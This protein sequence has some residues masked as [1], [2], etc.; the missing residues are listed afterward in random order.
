VEIV[1]NK[2]PSVLRDTC[3]TI[4]GYATHKY[5]EETV[6]EPCQIAKREYRKANKVRLAQN[7][8]IRNA[9]YA[10]KMSEGE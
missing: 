1:P 4:A 3:G 5:R 2:Y 10:R 8:S 6:C 9:E 7:R